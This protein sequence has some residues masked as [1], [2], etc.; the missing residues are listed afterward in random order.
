[1]CIKKKS[2]ASTVAVV[3]VVTVLSV[4]LPSCAK[5][6]IDNTGSMP[7]EQTSSVDSSQSSQQNVVSSSAD[8]QQS[9]NPPLPV[10]SVTESG[11]D[12]VIVYQHTD[13]TQYRSPVD[14]K[15]VTWEPLD[16]NE[17]RISS[18][19]Q[20]AVYA[21]ADGEAVVRK[22]AGWTAPFNYVLINHENG[23]QTIY[24]NLDSFAVEFGEKVK[25]GQKIG[26][27]HKADGHYSFRFSIRLYEDTL[28]I[29][30][31]AG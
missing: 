20:K 4:A 1:M 6:P 21:A 7:Q 24:R 30:I 31:P 18:E 23:I 9:S 25:K 15:G 29:N 19:E 17:V 16:D 22:K 13:S 27:M 14:T 2:V 12:E 11:E 3:L 26:E 28:E 5:N 8:A 10:S